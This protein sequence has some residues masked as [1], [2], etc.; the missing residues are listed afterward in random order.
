MSCTV[1]V[2]TGR[3]EDQNAEICGGVPCTN[4][5]L[6]RKD[7]CTDHAEECCQQLFCSVCL[8]EHKIEEHA[9]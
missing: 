8:E 1:E 9:K 7:I 2:R 3:P 5:A 4:C 6:C